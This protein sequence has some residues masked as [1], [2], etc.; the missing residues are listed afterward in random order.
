VTEVD[1]VE[2]LKKAEVANSVVELFGC[3]PHP[4]PLGGDA[5]CMNPTEANRSVCGCMINSIR[6]SFKYY[7]PKIRVALSVGSGDSLD[8]LPVVDRDWYRFAERLQSDKRNHLETFFNNFILNQ[9]MSSPIRFARIG[10]AR[11]DRHGVC[12]PM[13]DSLFPLPRN[14]WTEKFA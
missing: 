4:S 13:L 8:S 1:L 12:W 7:P 10:L 9:L 5:V 11:P 2:C 3:C 6:F 14:G